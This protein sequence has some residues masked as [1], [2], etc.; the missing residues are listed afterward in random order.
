MLGL[1]NIYAAEAFFGR[2]ST[3]QDFVDL[4]PK[5]AV[6]LHQPLAKFL[7]RAK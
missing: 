7:G 4:A 6:H 1:G 2:R 5:R 3:F